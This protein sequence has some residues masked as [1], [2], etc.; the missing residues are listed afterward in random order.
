MWHRTDAAIVI[1][2]IGFRDSALALLLIHRIAY[3]DEGK[4]EEAEEFCHGIYASLL[5]ELK[6]NLES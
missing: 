6:K 4:G 5:G 3:I 2:Q 1:P